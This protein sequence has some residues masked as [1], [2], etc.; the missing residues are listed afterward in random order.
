[1][2]LLVAT[3]L[4]AD[5]EWTRPHTREIAVFPFVARL[6]E[7][8]ARQ[9]GF[10]ADLAWPLSTW[11]WLTVRGHVDYQPLARD[12]SD[13]CR[14]V[15]CPFR[16]PEPLSPWAHMLSG[17][18]MVGFEMAPVFG[19]LSF[20]GFGPAELAIVVSTGIGAGPSRYPL[21]LGDGTR[22]L[23]TGWRFLVQ[24]GGG[25]RVRIKWLT[26]RLELR[27]L[28]YSSTIEQANGCSKENIKVLDTVLRAGAPFAPE[29]VNPTCRIAPN[30]VPLAYAVMRSSSG[31]LL[32]SVQLHAGL[33]IAF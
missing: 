22:H 1:M 25:F 26:V 33:G 4:A 11:F 2:V 17:A 8:S 32:T 18:A 9:Y 12:E 16:G 3:L 27:S 28:S 5:P 10:S 7:Y 14:Q 24:V 23:D 19:E 15:N 31:Q 13:V 20:H 6:G 30:E 21:H 29:A